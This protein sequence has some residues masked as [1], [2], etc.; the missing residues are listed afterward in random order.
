MDAN[1]AY[2]FKI[3]VG[4]AGTAGWGSRPVAA[5]EGAVAVASI[6]VLPATAVDRTGRGDNGSRLDALGLVLDADSADGVEAAWWVPGVPTFVPR[7]RWP[8]PLASLVT[9]LRASEESEDEGSAEAVPAQV[10]IAAPIP[11]ATASPPTRP[12]SA[13]E[14]PDIR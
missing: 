8:S 7:L 4:L 6:R 14:S 5:P 12:I 2:P 3:S 1:T 13:E 10:N 11:A 9:P